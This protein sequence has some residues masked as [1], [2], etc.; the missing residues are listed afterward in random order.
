M[1]LFSISVSRTS[2]QPDATKKKK[3]MAKKHFLL[4]P[5]YFEEAVRM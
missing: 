1:E 3:K 4:K 5:V 2:T